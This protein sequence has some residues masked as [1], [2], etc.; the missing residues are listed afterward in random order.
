MNKKT[1]KNLNKV[2]VSSEY[3]EMIK[4]KSEYS[5]LL[6]KLESNNSKEIR[7]TEKDLEEKLGSDAYLDLAESI[8]DL[9]SDKTGFCHK[10]FVFEIK[11]SAELDFED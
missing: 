10:G 4:P 3:E 8:S 1:G 5:M 2:E 6:A 11:V 7:I 9:I